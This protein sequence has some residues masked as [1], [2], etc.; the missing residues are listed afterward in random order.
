MSNVFEKYVYD[1]V[2]TPKPNVIYLH[3][4]NVEEKP[5]DLIHQVTSYPGTV[6]ENPY[7]ATK[8]LIDRTNNYK[9]Y[10][11]FLSNCIF[12]KAEP[13]TTAYKELLEKAIRLKKLVFECTC[14]PEPCHLDALR[15][16]LTKD[17]RGLGFNVESNQVENL[18]RNKKEED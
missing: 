15:L 13:Q 4:S 2:S 17:L 9:K 3:M 6:W 18:V 8:S 12:L 7:G 14:F 5:V 11:H 1:M 16:M 10:T